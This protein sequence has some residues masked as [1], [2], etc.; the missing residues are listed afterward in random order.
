MNDNKEKQK[1][2]E[3]I[4]PY[5]KFLFG[6]IRHRDSGNES[7]SSQEKNEHLSSHSRS[8][9]FD[10]WLFGRR[11]EPKKSATPTQFQI[12]KQVENLLNNVDFEL[13]M[14]TIDMLIDTANQYK[15]LMKEFTPFLN[16]FMKKI[17]AK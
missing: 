13:L 12:E 8:N 10:D 11:T 3:E 2:N 1:P 14:E 16:K 5:S 4:H 7:N 9:R 17:K 15:P 6:N